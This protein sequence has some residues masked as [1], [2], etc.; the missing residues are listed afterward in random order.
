MGGPGRGIQDRRPEWHA[1]AAC[2]D[3]EGVTWFP[4]RGKS[5]EPVRVI[6]AGC[7]VDLQCELYAV[8]LDTDHG[9]WAGVS[10]RQAKRS[11]GAA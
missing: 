5:A 1:D 3:A 6:C 7:P 10:V 8:G 4:D 2:R 9:I 11:Q